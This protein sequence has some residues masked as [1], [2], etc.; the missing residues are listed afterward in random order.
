MVTTINLV[1]IAILHFIKIILKY[2]RDFK[3]KTA[4][5][6]LCAHGPLYPS[7]PCIL[8][9]VSVCATLKFPNVLKFLG[10]CIF[11]HML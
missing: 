5:W 4:K 10:T 6:L 3:I 7:F 1:S 9:C 2:T 11:D 8:L